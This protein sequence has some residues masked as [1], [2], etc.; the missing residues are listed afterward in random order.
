MGKQASTGIHV[1]SPSSPRLERFSSINTSHLLQLR[2]H[3]F[4][5]RP[6]SRCYSFPVFCSSYFLSS[7]TS[8]SSHRREPL[9]VDAYLSQH[10]HRLCL[11]ACLRPS[12]QRQLFFLINLTAPANWRILQQQ[13]SGKSS[14]AAF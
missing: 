4:I 12:I 10:Q 6:L 9:A 8:P 2:P 1:K 3:S 5:S 14:S 7:F 11:F 13:L